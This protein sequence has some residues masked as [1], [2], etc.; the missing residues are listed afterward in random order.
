MTTE[1]EIPEIEDL[2]PLVP[3][4]RTGEVLNLSRATVW[5][6]IKDGTLEVAN[7][8]GAGRKN[9]VIKASIQ[10]FAQPKTF[11]SEEMA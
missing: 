6:R 3:I 10:R 4:K 11:H 2:P 7:G 1:T 9:L 8:P 5:R